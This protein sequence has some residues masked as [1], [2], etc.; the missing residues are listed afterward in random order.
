MPQP[1]SGT[2]PRSGALSSSREHDACGVGFVAHI[3]GHRSHAIVRQALEVLINLLHRGACGCEAN[4]GDGAGILIQVPDAFLRKV[5]VLPICRPP[6]R[7]ASAWSSC[8]GAGRPRG[9]PGLH[10]ADRREEGQRLLGWRDVPSRRRA[11]RRE[12]AW[13]SSRCSG[14]C[15][16]GTGPGRG[17]AG[18]PRALRAQALRDPQAHRAGRRPA[19]ASRAR[20]GPRS[21][22]S[23][24][25]RTRSSTRACS[26]ADQIEGM[27]PDLAD[28]DLDLGAGAGPPA[29]QHEHVPVVAARAPVPLR[30]AQRRDQHA[31]RQHQLDAGPRRPAEVE[32]LRRRPAEAAAGHPAR[33]AATT[34]AFDNVLEFLVMAGRPLAHAILM[35]IP[36]PLGADESMSRERRAFYEYHSSPDGAV[37][38]PGLDR[39]H[40]RHGHRRGARPE[41]PAAVALLRDPGRPGRHGLRGGR[42][43]HPSRARAAQG[44]RCTPDGSSWSTRPR[45]A[46]STTRRS[47]GSWPRE[48]PYGE[49]LK[50][51]L[52]DIEDLPP[53]HAER[54]GPRHG[55]PAAAG[56]R[57]HARRPA[58]RAGADG[59]A[60]RG[61]DRIDGHR[62]R[63]RRA[64]RSP[65]PAVRLLHAALR[66]G[67]QPAAR[68]HP[69][70]TGDDDGVGASARSATCSSPSRSRASRSRSPIPSCTTTRWPSCVICRRARRSGRRRS[71]CSSTRPATAPASSVRSI[72]CAGRRARRSPPATTS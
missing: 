2:P 8:R 28:P 44:A 40:R 19:A 6:A 26:T 36:E 27:F 15:S 5:V 23:A 9:D 38:R 37:G 41:R 55:L 21:T 22:S 51:H 42:A 56:L 34:A 61:A 32:R 31:P 29:V 46:S 57:L 66:A 25:R 50:R 1:N 17:R 64:V 10:R 71:R 20:P 69:R 63:A 54:P 59:R 47:S 70:G 62:H 7:T 30:G 49:W 12:R 65:A 53:A 16:S 58:P 52:V 35:M 4:T 45:A 60:G 13:R 39:V 43:R 68:R 3:K 67:H 72:S 24:C 14:S 18:R 11:A 48:H 33:A